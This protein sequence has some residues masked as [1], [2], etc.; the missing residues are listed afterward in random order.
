MKES[1]IT[2]SSFKREWVEG[3]MFYHL[4]KL[5]NG[6]TG[7]IGAKTKNPD[8]IQVGKILKYTIEEGKEFR[9]EKQWKIKAFNPNAPKGGG[10]RDKM[11]KTRVT[12]LSCLNAA[13]TFHS[14]SIGITPEDV[15]KT[16]NIFKTEAIKHNDKG[17]TE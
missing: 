5:E 12:F 17:V 16:A 11:N 8:E 15:L 7:E 10:G 1:K 9:G 2:E 6:D 4:I 3:G 14:G 13:A